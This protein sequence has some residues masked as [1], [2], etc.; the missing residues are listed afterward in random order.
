[1]NGLSGEEG[2]AEANLRLAQVRS[3]EVRAENRGVLPL[4]WR[5]WRSV[6]GLS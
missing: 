6:G 3:G 5:R 2:L 1:M 4:G